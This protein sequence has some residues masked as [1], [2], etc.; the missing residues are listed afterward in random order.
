MCIVRKER[1][2]NSESL[3]IVSWVAFL[4]ISCWFDAKIVIGQAQQYFQL[5]L[6]KVLAEGMSLNETF[7]VVALIEKLS[8][9]WKD[10][11]NY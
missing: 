1:T 8:P 7:Q 9:A 3:L 10:F 2:K 6:N 11:K 4:I 5:I